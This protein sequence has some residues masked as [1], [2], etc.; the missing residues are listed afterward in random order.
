MKKRVPA[1][2]LFSLDTPSTEIPVIKIPEE[3]GTKDFITRLAN[4][5]LYN[6][7]NLVDSIAYAAVREQA[8]VLDVSSKVVERMHNLLEKA[9]EPTLVNNA[10]FKLEIVN[11]V[12]SSSS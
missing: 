1:P 8:I 10:V 4:K 11:N 9:S 7:E 5:I 2:S 3:R 12:A 6:T